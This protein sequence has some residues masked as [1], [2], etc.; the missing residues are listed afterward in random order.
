MTTILIGLCRATP[1]LT[2]VQFE[3]GICEARDPVVR[4]KWADGS[5]ISL[6]GP[7]ADEFLTGWREASS[8]PDPETATAYCARYYWGTATGR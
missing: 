4:L 8:A 5:E 7:G 3:Q 1:P 2:H 6:E